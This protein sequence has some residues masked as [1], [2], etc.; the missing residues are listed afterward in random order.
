M[1]L[2]K[3]YT[4]E[5]AAREARRAT[6]FVLAVAVPLIP[7]QFFGMVLTVFSLLNLGAI[8]LLSARAVGK[9]NEVD[10]KLAES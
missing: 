10:W 1:A 5:N 4:D 7:L 9:L 3:I 2:L 6:Y 8:K